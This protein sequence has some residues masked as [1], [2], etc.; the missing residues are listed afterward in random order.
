M[1]WQHLLVAVVE[2]RFHIVVVVAESVQV[3]TK[4]LPCTHGL[5][6]FSKEEFLDRNQIFGYFSRLTAKKRLAEEANLLDATDQ[7]TVERD[8]LAA[9]EQTAISS[10]HQTVHRLMQEEDANTANDVHVEAQQRSTSAKSK[11]TF[12]KSNK[13]NPT[14]QRILDTDEKEKLASTS[15]TKP[16]RVFCN[17]RNA[18]HPILNQLVDRNVSI[19]ILKMNK[20]PIQETKLERKERRLCFLR[21]RLLSQSKK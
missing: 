2:L 10:I 13:T 17:Q 15:S 19:P 4:A 12:S 7:R 14:L 6:L 21:L 8:N 1:K 3:S 11:S 16:K 20:K 9:N 18:A 5:P